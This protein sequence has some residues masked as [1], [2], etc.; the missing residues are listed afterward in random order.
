MALKQP[1]FWDR[2]DISSVDMAE[3]EKSCDEVLSRAKKMEAV[4]DLQAGRVRRR[5][6]FLRT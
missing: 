6:I 3:V 2:L 5:R 1:D 4:Y